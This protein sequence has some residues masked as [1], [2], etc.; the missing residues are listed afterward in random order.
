MATL[1]AHFPKLRILWSR[2]PHETLRLFKALK[3][4]H[5]EV[6]VAKAVDVGKK[7]SLESLLK[8]DKTDEGGDE[9]NEEDEINEAGRDMLLQLPGVTIQLARKIMH[10][11]DCLADLIA[12]NRDQLRALA[13]PSVGQK[14][15][16]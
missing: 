12:L 1:T 5:E 8:S 3:A 10:E 9:E 15:F 11:C 14:L 6:D 7:D 2:S 16:T 13:G 4:N